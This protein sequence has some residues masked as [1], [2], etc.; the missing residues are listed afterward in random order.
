MA[1]QTRGSEIKA[2]GG[3]SVIPSQ[4]TVVLKKQD[5]ST[6]RTVYVLDD[7]SKR[8]LTGTYA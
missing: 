2:K 4:L 6:K 3:E 5:P 8:I 7:V 1:A